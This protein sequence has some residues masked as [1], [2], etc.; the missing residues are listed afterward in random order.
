MGTLIE[1]AAAVKAAQEAID[2]AIVAK[3]GTTEGGLSN[4]AAAIAAIPSG[5]TAGVPDGGWKNDGHTHLW[6][7]VNESIG[8]EIRLSI[9]STAYAKYDATVEWGDGTTLVVTNGYI[10]KTHTYAESGEY[11]IT[12]KSQNM[13]ALRCGSGSE[14][15][16]AFSIMYT[17]EYVPDAKLRFAELSGE[18][19]DIVGAFAN[20]VRLEG[21]KG[22]S[23]VKYIGGY[24][25]FW[26]SSLVN[27][28]GMSGVERIANNAFTSCAYD[29]VG[30][31]FD[32]VTSIGNGAF[33]NAKRMFGDLVFPSLD[34]V[35]SI[36]GSSNA[37]RSVD[38]SQSN[39]TTVTATFSYNNNIK[40]LKLPATLTSLPALAV[41]F[42]S[43]LGELWVYAVEPPSIESTTFTAAPVKIFVPANSV[44][45][46]KAATNWSAWADKIE[47]IPEEYL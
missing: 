19:T 29:F 32:N 40:I 44:A 16:N 17:N 46:Y 21:I 37:V 6:V 28:E 5:K 31:S 11:I 1:N 7:E 42:G 38:M 4:A 13:K 34:T 12:I 8:M 22:T 14:T 39:I 33:T 43:A 30:F 41:R 20:C 9:N 27:I 15:S 25:F 3:G 18:I 24:T 26:C 35:G 10:I 36:F 45:A 2:A 47:A 23:S